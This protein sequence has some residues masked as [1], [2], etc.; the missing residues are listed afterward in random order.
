MPGVIHARAASGVV[1]LMRC[2]SGV[3]MLVRCAVGV[4]PVF[5]MYGMFSHGRSS[6]I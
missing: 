6:S 4:F 3:V 1:M 5:L 2:V